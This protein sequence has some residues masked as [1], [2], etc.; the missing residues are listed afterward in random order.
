MRALEIFKV[1][2]RVME[3]FGVTLLQASTNQ[4]IEPTGTEIL[5]L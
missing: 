3:V 2:S 4:G 1:L 5:S